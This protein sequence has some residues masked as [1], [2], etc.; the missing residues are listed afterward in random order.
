MFFSCI[1][2]VF[3]LNSWLNIRKIMY[4]RLS[5]KNGLVYLLLQVQLKLVAGP[6]QKIHELGLLEFWYETSLGR[7]RHHKK[8][9]QPWSYFER[10]QCFTISIVI[11]SC[12]KFVWSII[13]ISKTYFNNQLCHGSRSIINHLGTIHDFSYELISKDLGTIYELVLSW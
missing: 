6:Y 11:C 10:Y 13:W 8:S 12:S 3:H 1:S 9:Q 5:L 4:L 7:N 2:L